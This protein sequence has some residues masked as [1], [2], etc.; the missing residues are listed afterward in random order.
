MWPGFFSAVRTCPSLQSCA[1]LFATRQ[2]T[3]SVRLSAAFSALA[4]NPGQFTQPVTRRSVLEFQGTLA[5]VRQILGAQRSVL[6][7][8]SIRNAAVS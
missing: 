8:A 5:R 4:S 2:P 1:P 6:F 7:K 3:R